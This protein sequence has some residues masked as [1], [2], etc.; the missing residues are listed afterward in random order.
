MDG[1]NVVSTKIRKTQ[2][3]VTTQDLKT[4]FSH[5]GT[6]RTKNYKIH[7]GLNPTAKA[8]LCAFVALCETD[9]SSSMRVPLGVNPKSAIASYDIPHTFL[10]QPMI[11][12]TH[13]K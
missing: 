1:N 5:E 9:L 3:I 11:Y 6:K 12:F 10:L 4:I 7:F 2:I 13:E 8:F